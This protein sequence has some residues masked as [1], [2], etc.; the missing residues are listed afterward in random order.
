MDC[1]NT[2]ISLQEKRQLILK[3]IENKFCVDSKKAQEIYLNL[4]AFGRAV[5]N[6]GQY[7]K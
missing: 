2:T 3:R 4:L 7:G 6:Y 1:N 5:T